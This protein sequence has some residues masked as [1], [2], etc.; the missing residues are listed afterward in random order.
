MKES[1]AKTKW[2]PIYRV[3]FHQELSHN[4]IHDGVTGNCIGSKCMWWVEITPHLSNE[5]GEAV[6][7]SAGYCGAVK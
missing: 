5:N 3:G 4:R 1:D 2:C 7:Y 6:Y